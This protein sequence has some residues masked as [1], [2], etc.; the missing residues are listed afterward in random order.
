MSLAWAPSG[1]EF[2]TGSYDRTIRVYKYNANTSREIYH[3]KRMQRVFTVK[4]SFDNNFIM[5]GS[6]DGNLRVW[7]AVADQELGILNPRETAAKQYR[8]SLIQRHQ[9]LPEVKKI[10][11]SRKIPKAI[12]NQT[13]QAITQKKS[14]QRKHANRVKNGQGKF[15]GERS[16]TVVREEE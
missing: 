1:R 16:K 4:Y 5:S 10:Y 13:Q 9:H 11:H 12:R 8:Q 3:T 2:V 6:D 14:Q 7:K 15:V